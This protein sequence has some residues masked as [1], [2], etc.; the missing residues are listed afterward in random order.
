MPALGQI[1][2]TCKMGRYLAGSQLCFTSHGSKLHVVSGI[3]GS[4]LLRST[5]LIQDQGADPKSPL[6]CHLQPQPERQ[7]VQL[8]QLPF[9][10]R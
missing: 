6:Q 9:K 7:D 3:D 8:R 5:P 4:E 2:R 10:V 1:P